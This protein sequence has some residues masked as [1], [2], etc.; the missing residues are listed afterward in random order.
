MGSFKSGSQEAIFNLTPTKH[1]SPGDLGRFG[2]C[3]L[4]FES[5]A[6]EVGPNIVEM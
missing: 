5:V 3:A 6:L 1:P 4:G 2:T